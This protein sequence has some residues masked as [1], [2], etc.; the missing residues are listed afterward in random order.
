MQIWKQHCKHEILDGWQDLNYSESFNI[1]GRR[2]GCD[3]YK[4]LLFDKN[5]SWKL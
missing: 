2:E 4:L 5:L 3:Q 1:K